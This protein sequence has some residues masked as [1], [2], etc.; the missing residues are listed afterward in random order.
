MRTKLRLLQMIIFMLGLGLLS[1]CLD[2]PE[3]DP[4]QIPAYMEDKIYDANEKGVKLI[5]EGRY[6]EAI[7]V[8]EEAVGY[9]YEVDPELEQL[10]YEKRVP[11]LLDVPFNNLSWAHHDK[12]DYEQA[13]AYAEK[14]MLMLPN[15]DIEN[16]NRA[17]ALYA[18]DRVDEAEACYE[19]AISLNSDNPEA[20]Y[21][22]G[23][24]QYDREEY[25]SALKNFNSYLRTY[26]GD[27]DAA[28]MR[29]YT[30]L[31]L[32][33][34]DVAEEYADNFMKKYSD[35]YEG[36]WPKGAYLEDTAEYE[37]IISFH[38]GIA[39][40]YPAEWPA[41]RKLGEIYYDYSEYEAALEVFEASAATFPAEI[42]VKEWLITVYGDLG[43]I[44]GAESLYL[45]ADDPDHRL[46]A[47]L[48]QMYLDNGYYQ[49]AAAAFNTMTVVD[50][51]NQEGYVKKL[52]ALSWGKRYAKCAEFGEQ[53]LEKVE[54]ITSDIPWYT[55]WC[56]TE[57]G[58]EASADKHF[59]QAVEIDPD[60]YE[61]WSYLALAQLNLGNE[62][63]ARE[64]SERALEIY[65][66]DSTAI[67]VKDTLDSYSEPLGTRIKQ[68]FKDNYLYG[69][70]AAKLE[71][72]LAELDTPGLTDREI[73]AI[74]DQAKQSDDRFT[75]LIY[76][77][78]Y[79]GLTEVGESDIAYTDMGDISYFKIDSFSQTTD[80]LFTKLIDDIPSPEEK[81]LVLD[82]RGNGGGLTESANNM[83]DLLLP[84]LVTST[85][86]YRDGTTYNYYSDPEQISFRNIAIFVDENSAS[87]AELLTLGLKTYADDVTIIGRTTFGK[88]VGQLV[89]EDRQHKVMLL[90]VN[91]YWNVMQNNVSDTRIVPDITVKG[92]Q[93]ESFMSKVPHASS[94]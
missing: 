5:E 14:S 50:P 83:L 65:E 25:T 55:G 22:L 31:R 2:L 4:Y 76:G 39:K 12:G 88:G 46:L 19:E 37:K 10:D 92:N 94:R 80:D 6:E 73:A 71:R 28:S 16:V 66:W 41:Q 24:I 61:A 43:D 9:V 32:D 85:L 47:T 26:P 13:L 63:E 51:D 44:V 53:T 81:T 18:L 90:A 23:M 21:G 75:F 1:G 54:P 91:H 8:L 86:I 69:K 36:T 33:R 79:D 35:S 77:D 42:E 57:M 45:D 87:A 78:Y 62:E 40:Q 84:E 52:Q 49:M 60:D 82:L 68:F 38:K 93:L 27:G 67:Y 30:L 34:D 7:A 74:I 11:V 3:A 56:E 48:G 17:N 59:R 72:S 20:H 29:V 58:D 64:Y 89:F 70:D 15:D